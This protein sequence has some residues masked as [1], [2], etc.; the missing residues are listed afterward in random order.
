MSDT[1][2]ESTMTA[3]CIWEEVIHHRIERRNGERVWQYSPPQSDFW[4]CM[5]EDRGAWQHR[6]ICAALAP[7]IDALWDELNACDELDHMAFDW[8]FIPAV[9]GII[10]RDGTLSPEQYEDL[11]YTLSRF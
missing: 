4:Q 2:K 6:E 9:L 1:I 5:I 7:K 3:M 11:K 10:N 8:D